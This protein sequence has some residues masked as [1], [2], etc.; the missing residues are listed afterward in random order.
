MSQPS[1]FIDAAI[2][3]LN[4]AK[5]EAQKQLRTLENLAQE[6]QGLKDQLTEEKFVQARGAI[7]HNEQA[8]QLANEKNKN[9]DLTTR[10]D[11]MQDAFGDLVSTVR[12]QIKMRGKVKSEDIGGLKSMLRTS[13][14][15][16][17]LA[18]S[19]SEDSSSE[20]ER[21]QKRRGVT[22]TKYTGCSK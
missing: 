21:V 5:T 6:N 4:A 14:R 17:G 9:K 7:A 3:S 8:L 20:D 12:T 22:P 16:F 11:K 10:S 18:I 15:E 19:D 1:P 13:A 2:L